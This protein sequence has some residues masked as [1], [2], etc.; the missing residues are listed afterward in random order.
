MKKNVFVMIIMS[1]L[2]SVTAQLILKTGMNDYGSISLG[3]D[4]IRAVFHPLVFVGLITY[5]FS[6]VLW[7]MVLSKVEVSYAYPFAALG[8]VIVTFLGWLL[9]NESVNALRIIGVIIIITGVYVVS[10]SK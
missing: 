4:I 3:L 5:F 1:T 9:L 2:L 8:Y 6:A 7:I 10:K